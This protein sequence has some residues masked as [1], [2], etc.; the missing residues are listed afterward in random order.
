MMKMSFDVTARKPFGV[1]YERLTLSSEGNRVNPEN[2]FMLPLGGG[3]W[4]LLMWP[5]WE[6]TRC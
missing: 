3:V 2:M 1:K 6:P 4:Y 5:R